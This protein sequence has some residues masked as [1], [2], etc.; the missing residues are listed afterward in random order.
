MLFSL[1]K[2]ADA[3]PK[4]NAEG[5]YAFLARSSRPEIHRV[6][7]LLE[8]LLAEFP[9][10]DQAELVARIQ[11]GDDVQ[12]RSATFEV[13][14]HAM[15]RRLGYE[16]E[17]H[18][19]LPNGS[20][21]RPDFLV[22]SPTGDRFYVEAVL[23]SEHRGEDPASNARM[24][25]VLDLIAKASHPNFLIEIDTEGAPATPPQGKALVRQ[26]LRWL[27]GLNP[28]QV[29]QQLDASGEAPVFN[30]HH[31][32]W[33]LSF[34]PI[35]LKPERRGKASTLIGLHGGKAGIVD[36]WTPIRAAVKHK[37]G[38]YGNLE[39]PLVVAVNMDSF[40]LDRIDEMQALYGEEQFWFAADDPHLEPRFA[41]APNGAWRGKSGAESRRVSAAWLFN[42]VT[43][44][45][46]A[47]RRS[48]L[49]VNPWSNLTIA[50]CLRRLPHA[51]PEA[52]KMQWLEGT[53]IR[54]LL[55]VHEAWPE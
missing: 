9:A 46:I 23:A 48:T 2:Q 27:D 39:L 16:M 22:T 13:L 42:D 31:E 34:R 47:T 43:I 54:E 6:R 45:S 24:A 17:S 12:F 21:A 29:K 38:K 55:G 15:L 52:E 50:P 7:E 53:S 36:A 5:E 3:S 35:P 19:E 11:S 51:Y 37:G 14:I 20:K 40:H 18:P 32:D 44:Y 41:R 28:E 1:A 8:G 49:Y 10:K 4:L 30:W 33:K 26:V 25:V